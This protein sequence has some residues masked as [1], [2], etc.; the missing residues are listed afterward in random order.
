MVSLGFL[1]IQKWAFSNQVNSNFSLYKYGSLKKDPLGI[2]DLPE[3]FNYTIISK[4]G[5]LMNDGFLLP[6]KPD[7]MASF[8]L[9]DV[10]CIV[11]RNHELNP[12]QFEI[13]GPF[14]SQNQLLSKINPNKIYDYGKGKLPSVG[15]TSNFVYNLKT[16]K[17]EKQFL[18]LVG[19][20]RNCAGGATPWNTWLTCEEDV[21]V[22]NSKNETVEKNHGYVFEV[23]A[24]DK[25]ELN[26]PVPLKAMGRFNH[27][28][29]CVDPNTGIVYLTE[30]THDSCL[31]RFIPNFKGE[32]IKG[33]KLQA[34]KIKDQAKFETRNWEENTMPINRE[35]AIEWLD[36]E[37]V[38]SEQDDLRHRAYEQGAAVFARGEGIWFGENEFYFA[39]TSGGKLKN[40]QIFKYQVSTF[41]GTSLETNNPAKLS[42]FVQADNSDLMSYCD[43]LT[44]APWGDLVI[45]EDTRSPR[46]L[47]IN[48]EGVLYPIAHN[49]GHQSEFTGGCFSPDGSTY[50]VNIQ[51]AGLTIAI[52]G[53]WV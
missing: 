20:N 9:D 38:D 14:G 19:T 35:Y 46:I 37:N 25:E 18:S 12:I 45:C 10:R 52:T 11:V 47:G 44:I 49:V 7:G 31:Y 15:G 36:L 5:D 33:G 1:G 21:T 51:D 27:E 16:G 23:P 29:V 42:L 22:V 53:P 28:A 8:P 50:F 32:L 30:D 43:N 40:G 17:I 34:L 48:K 3:G 6:G 24:T 39:C 26:T 2:V 4:V 41:E 13:E